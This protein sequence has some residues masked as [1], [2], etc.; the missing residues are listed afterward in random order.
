MGDGAAISAPAPQPESCRCRSLQPLREHV[1]FDVVAS[2]EAVGELREKGPLD[3]MVVV[4]RHVL[5]HQAVVEPIAT[6]RSPDV[7][8]RSRD[9]EHMDARCRRRACRAVPSETAGAAN[10]ARAPSAMTRRASFR[11]G[12]MLRKPYARHLGRLNSRA[13]H[14]CGACLDPAG[15]RTID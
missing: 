6:L 10:T 9:A 11:S 8:H 1:L 5:V 12:I 4:S 13:L 7:R 15:P 14:G 3:G 2:Q